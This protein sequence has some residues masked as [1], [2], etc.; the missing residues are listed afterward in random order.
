[1]WA[2]DEKAICTERKCGGEEAREAFLPFHL[3]HFAC[4]ASSSLVQKKIMALN[5]RALESGLKM[6]T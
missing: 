4:H 1:M 6:W 3:K 5:L 2:I